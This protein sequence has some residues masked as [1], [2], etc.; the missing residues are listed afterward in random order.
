MR[1]SNEQLLAVVRQIAL[2]GDGLCDATKQ[3]ALKSFN[4][5]KRQNEFA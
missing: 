3:E 2:K 4:F 5:Q 1:L